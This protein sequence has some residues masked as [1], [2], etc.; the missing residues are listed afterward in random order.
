MNNEL[1]VSERRLRPPPPATAA[2]GLAARSAQWPG[3]LLARAG[4]C[5]RAAWHR[6]RAQL[7]LAGRS[8]P[9]RLCLGDGA[10]IAGWI[11]ELRPDARGALPLPDHS[12]ALIYARLRPGRTLLRECARVLEPGGGLRLVGDPSAAD[13]DALAAAGFARIERCRAGVSRR[14]ELAGI[15]ARGDASLI[16]EAWTAP[17][18]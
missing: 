17:Q 9:L 4:A 15:E 1:R 12:V 18:P 5:L 13:V 6:Q 8:G 2:L 11:G 16:V 14:P 10:R 3:E 7:V